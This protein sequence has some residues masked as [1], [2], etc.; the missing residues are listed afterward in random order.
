MEDPPTTKKP[1][2]SA[3]AEGSAKAREKKALLKKARAALVDNI[4]RNCQ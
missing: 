2:M 4:L 3:A 1:R